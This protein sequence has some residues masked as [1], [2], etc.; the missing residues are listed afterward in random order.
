MSPSRVSKP[1]F[2]DL[3]ALARE[4]WVREMARRLARAGFNDYRR[5]DALALRWLVHGPLPLATLTTALGVSRQATR[6]VVEG[7]VERGYA[8]VNVDTS[9]SRRRNADLTPVGHDYAEAVI[10]VLAA[11]NSE[12]T[13]KVDPGDLDTARFVLTFVKDNFGL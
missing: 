10:E 8:R 4:G 5:S 6:K 7:L 2:G 12:L 13:I 11:L 9:D 1:L 3:L